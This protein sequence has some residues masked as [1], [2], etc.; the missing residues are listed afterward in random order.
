MILVCLCVRTR[1]PT[2][3]KAF[4]SSQTCP[5]RENRLEY[6]IITKKEPQKE[7]LSPKIVIFTRELRRVRGHLTFQ[8]VAF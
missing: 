6:T 5:D 8:S 4:S 1:F 7:R 3:K 2:G